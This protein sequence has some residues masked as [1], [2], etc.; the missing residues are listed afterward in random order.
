M[1]YVARDFNTPTNHLGDMMLYLSNNNKICI[2]ILNLHE[3]VNDS[4]GQALVYVKYNA[5]MD[6]YD[7]MMSI[8]NKLTRDIFQE[9]LDDGRKKGYLNINDTVE[10]ITFPYKDVIT[11]PENNNT[12]ENVMTNGRWGNYVHFTRESV[13]LLEESESDRDDDE[14]RVGYYIIKGE[15]SENGEIVFD[16]PIQSMSYYRTYD[17][18]TDREYFTDTSDD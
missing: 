16:K 4:F 18:D 3:H 1:I 17:S 10:S 5:G 15:F 8:M 6:I 9:M 11:V 7:T 13:E 14:K 2:N 12:V